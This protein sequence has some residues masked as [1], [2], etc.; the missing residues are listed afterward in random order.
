[1]NIEKVM[2][3][4]THVA[5]PHIFVPNKDVVLA[6]VE[7]GNPVYFIQ[8]ISFVVEEEEAFLVFDLVGKEDANWFRRDLF[9]GVAYVD[10]YKKVDK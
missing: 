6:L 4:Y 10:V 3:L 9:D 2:L 8:S 7:K 1:M 5:G